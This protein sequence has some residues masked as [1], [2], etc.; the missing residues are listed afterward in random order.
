MTQRVTMEDIARGAGVS[1]A[2][3]SLVLRHK[4]GINEETRRRVFNTARELGY[5]KHSLLT[6][7]S[8]PELQQIGLLMKLCGDSA[9]YANPFY[10]PILASIEATCRKRQIN[11]LVAFMPVDIDNHPQELPRLLM[12][13]QTDAI[14]MAGAFVDQTINQL[15]EKPGKPVVLIDAYSTDA[16]Y[17]TVVSDNFRGAYHAVSHLIAAGHRHIGLVGALP[18]A[19]PS[20]ADRRRG[21]EQALHDHAIAERYFADAHLDNNDEVSVATTKLLQRFPQVTALFCANDMAAISALTAA[22]ALGRRLP[23]ELSVIGFDDIETAAHVTPALTTM[24]VDKATMGRLAV[25]LLLNR[26]ES[27]ESSPVTVLLRPTLVE[28]ESVR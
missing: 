4:P 3:V 18:D 7:N 5:R 22:R 10:G 6:L 14:I 9:P 28:R 15:L 21:Y 11:L 19:Y 2:T 1:L 12:D 20:I 25:Q 24:R 23:E 17:D 27:P 13:N 8:S 26:V 16:N